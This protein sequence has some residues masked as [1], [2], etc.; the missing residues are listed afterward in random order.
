MSDAWELYRAEN[1][2]VF[3]NRTYGSRAGAV[4]CPCGDVV[5]VQDRR[6]GLIYNQ[7][8]QPDRMAYD[9]HYQN[10]QAFSGVFSS[11][12]DEVAAI[13]QRCFQGM[14]LIE[15]GCG[16]GRFLEQ[17]QSLGF[18]ITGL[19]PAYEGK[20]PNIVKAPFSPSL[21]MTAQGVILRHVLEHV[22]DPVGFLEQIRDANG[23][24]GWIYIEVPCF[25][26]ICRQRAWFDIY[27]EHVNYFRLED[28]R[29]M[30]G[31]VTESGWIFGDQYGYVVAD[32]ARLKVPVCRAAHRVD[33]PADFLHGIDHYG[34]VVGEWHAAGGEK[35]NT[36]IWGGA[37]KGVL[38]A[39]FMQR[40]GVAVDIVIDINPAKQGRRLP[41][42]GLPVHSP[43][44]ALSILHPGAAVFVMNP[45]YLDEIVVQSD[46]RYTYFTV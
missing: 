45:N 10:E 2:P 12:L 43:E 16:K 33:F 37:S 20:N 28:L 22:P 29:R 30:F 11:H 42:S 32:L 9:A 26:W 23:G 34:K 40:A 39:L 8:F 27:Y 6:T 46:N 36:A 24:G 4:S 19:D 25:D 35:K 3:Q 21:G 31:D 14:S 44:S 5:L 38:F 17:L 13:I 1:L 15:V 7:A 18:S 41:A